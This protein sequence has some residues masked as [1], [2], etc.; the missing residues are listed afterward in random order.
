MGS[1]VWVAVTAG[2]VAVAVGGTL[3]TTV[4]AQAARAIRVA[5][6]AITA[7]VS[8]PMGLLMAVNGRPLGFDWA[9]STWNTSI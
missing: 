8:F 9:G 6:A 2:T 4:W 3:S 5:A 7:A 1:G